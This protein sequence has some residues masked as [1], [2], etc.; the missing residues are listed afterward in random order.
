MRCWG[1]LGRDVPTDLDHVHW[2]VSL[3]GVVGGL[4]KDVPTDPERCCRGRV[5]GGGWMG[6]WVGGW[7]TRGRPV[8]AW[9]GGSV[10]RVRTWL[11]TLFKSRGG[12]IS[13]KWN[14]FSETLSRNQQQ[15]YQA[16]PPPPSKTNNAVLNSPVFVSSTTTGAG[17]VIFERRTTGR[18]VLD[19]YDCKRTT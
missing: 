14:V 15:Y 19:D 1:V 13:S 8:L 12:R 5:M 16:Q 2:V 6:G 18:E 9:G 11:S 10:I 3:A 7:V 17:G 4:G